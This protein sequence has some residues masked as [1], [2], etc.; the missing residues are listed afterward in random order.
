MGD[1]VALAG[2]R[3]LETGI[4]VQG[5]LWS[6]HDSTPDEPLPL[7]VANDGREYAELADLTGFLGVMGDER[8]QLRCRA[9]LLDPVDRDRS[10][11]A[12][13]PM[14][15]WWSTACFR[16]WPTNEPPCGDPSAWAPASA[17]WWRS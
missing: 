16:W 3:S 4:A 6:P 2:R 7:L 5:A 8:P 1:A 15:G 11:S 10:F 12:S 14:V 17:R 9:L 13:P